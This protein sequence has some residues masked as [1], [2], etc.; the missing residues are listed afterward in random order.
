MTDRPAGQPAARTPLT[1]YRLQI[2]QSFDL[3]AAAELIDYVHDLGADW[4]YLSPLLQ[5]E[6]G[7][8]HGYDVVDHSRVDRARGGHAGLERA[9]AAAHAHGMGVLVDIVPN[10]V[11]VATPA[12]MR[13]WWDVLESRSRIAS[14]GGVR[15]RL[16]LR[17][18]AP[19]H[20][21]ARQ[22]R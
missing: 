9:A 10:H 16:G 2:R 1:A 22:R 3:D 21:G 12:A 4:V 8:D 17:R 7:S 6:A 14:C 5:A 20:P 18:R 19:A 11:G 15:H 13:W